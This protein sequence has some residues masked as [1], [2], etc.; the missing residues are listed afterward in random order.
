MASYYVNKNVQDNGITRYTELDVRI[1]R[2]RRTS[3]SS[4]NS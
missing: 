4:E 2:I 3:S 1:Y